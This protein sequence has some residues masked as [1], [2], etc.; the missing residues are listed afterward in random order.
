MAT[1]APSSAT[2][3]NVAA[4]LPKLND[5]DSDIR[6]MGLSD[7]HQLLVT[8]GPSLLVHD[9]HVSAKTVDGLLHTLQ[10]NNGEVQNMVSTY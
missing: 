5:E 3:H 6:F 7:L 8:N 1:P 2:S 9:I 4:L 10:D